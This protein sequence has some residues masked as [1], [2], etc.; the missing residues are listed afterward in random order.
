MPVAPP[1]HRPPGWSPPKRERT[2][3]ADRYYDSA[4]WKKLAVECKKRDGYQCRDPECRTPDR[5]RGGRVVADH[6]VPR[7]QGGLDALSNLV[8]RCNACH[9]RVTRRAA[10]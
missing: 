1:I 5:G 7:R 6:V 2:D 10:K 4:E 8:T 3:A 9:E